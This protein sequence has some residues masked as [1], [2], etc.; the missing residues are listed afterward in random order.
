MTDGSGFSI[1]LIGFGEVGE[2]FGSELASHGVEVVAYDSLSDDPDASPALQARARKAGV[3]LAP[4]QAAAQ[5]DLVL[6]L[7]TTQVALDVAEACAKLLRPDAIFL[8]LN[9]TSPTVKIEIQRVIEAGGADFVEGAILGAVGATGAHTRTLLAGERAG[10]VAQRL[11]DLGLNMEAYSAQVGQASA[12]KMIRSVFSKGFEVI[13]IEMLVAG[14]E[15]GIA[16]DLW[17]DA[18]SFMD[19]KPF[20][21]IANNWITS[22][23]VAHERRYHEMRQVLETLK[24]LGVDPLLTASTMAFFKRSG[25]LNLD[26]SFQQKPDDWQAVIGHMANELKIASNQGQSRI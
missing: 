12:F 11:N 6:S 25:D 15:A 20:A 1:G 3:R 17:A 7:V 14:H 9:S 2:V 5:T 26:D 10:A 18:T 19:K 8:D 13:L 22:H 23:V 4:L 16:Q 24:E 21:A